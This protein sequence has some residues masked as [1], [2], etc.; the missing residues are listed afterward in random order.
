M[1]APP[2]QEVVTGFDVLAVALASGIAFAALWLVPPAA[3][4]AVREEIQRRLQG[5]LGAVL[6]LLTLTSIAVLVARSIAISGA[7][8]ADLGDVLPLVL[9]RTDFGHAWLAR[10]AAVVL[11]W[12]LWLTRRALSSMA[13]TPAAWLVFM[14]IAV[15]AYTRSATGHAGDHGDFRIPVWIDWLHLLAA[16]LWG[17]VIVAFLIAARPVVARSEDLSSRALVVRRFS[18]LAA[19]G[20]FLAAATGVYNAWRELG[21]W[22]PL[23]TTYFGLVLDIKLALVIAMALA[24][25]SNRFWHVPR[26]VGASAA[27]PARALRALTKTVTAEALLWLAI[28]A[29]VAL[30]LHGMPPA[31]MR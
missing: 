29:T 5:F 26:I 2:W 8:L 19:A 4:A 12:V 21:G 1:V 10:A 15:I 13:R 9:T 14:L 20:L 25:A 17:G 23:W 27:F 28:L 22:Q 16:G 6:G 24:G 7:G 31:S 11:L 3:G 18:S 30:L